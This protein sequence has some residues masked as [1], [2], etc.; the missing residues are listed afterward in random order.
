MCGIVA[1]I[2]GKTPR[3]LYCVDSKVR[4]PADMIQ[5]N[6]GSA[7]WKIEIRRDAGKIDHLETFNYSGT[8]RR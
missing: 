6:C 2:G 5:R 3:L 8:P 7:K 1:Y 4:I